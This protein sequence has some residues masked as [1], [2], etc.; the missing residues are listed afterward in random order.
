MAIVQ[1]IGNALAQPFRNAVDWIKGVWGGISGWFG[2][3]A[4]SIGGAISNVTSK[5]TAPFQAA[6]EFVKGIPQKMVDAVSN[7]G[8]LLRNKLGDWDIPGPL[9]KVRDVIP[10][11]ATGGFTGRGGK[12][13]VAGLVHKGEYVIPKEGVNQ[14]TGQP[15]GGGGFHV[16]VHGNI[17][18]QT[19]EAAR[20]WFAELNRQAE[21]AGQGF[22]V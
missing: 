16:E 7:V 1:P 5:L 2:G 11:F 15:Y 19:P 8:N 3:I 22:A 9:G 20:A 14:A 4:N 10:G 13:D 17:I 12:Y 21:L 18:N 6:F